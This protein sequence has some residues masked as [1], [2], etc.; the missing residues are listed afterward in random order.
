[1]TFPVLVSAAGTVK[2]SEI[3]WMGT[4]NSAN[5]E[6]LELKNETSS[7]VSLDGWTLKAEDGQPLITLSG[8]LAGNGYFLLERT[9]DDVV[10][11]VAAD[12]I[13]SGA[14]SNTGEVL[15]LRDASGIEQDRMNASAGWPAGDNTTKDTMQLVD[16][17]WLTGTPTPKQQN[18]GQPPATTNDSTPIAT[19]T[20][21]TSS[22]ATMPYIAPEYKPKF[23]VV[24]QG[25]KKVSTY[26]RSTF[27]ASAVGHNGEPLVG[28]YV[29]YAWNFGDG[30]S[31]D[32]MKVEKAFNYPGAYIIRLTVIS[33]D[34]QMS[35]EHQVR[36]SEHAVA[37]SEALPGAKGWIELVNDAS[38][39]AELSG[40]I[41]TE[42]SS[43]FVFPDGSI[44]GAQSG[45]VLD[46]NVTGIVLPSE[47]LDVTLHDGNGHMIDE[48]KAD[49][50]PDGATFARVGAVLTL[51]RPTPGGENIALIPSLAKPL[52]LASKIFSAPSGIAPT[53][54][55]ITQPITPASAVGSSAPNATPAAQQASAN[56]TPT[57]PF[58]TNM[59]WL[60]GSIA[61]GLA[62]GG[63]V[64]FVMR[65]KTG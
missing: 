36:V 60:L 54:N 38:T 43:R 48:L 24:I 59:L 16:G 50:V 39:P 61:G 13:Y 4:A 49:R 10:P 32:G 44:I 3:A 31:K 23:G 47:A 8:T 6:W 9:D 17:V 37:L 51:A 19:S 55:T 64:R 58:T 53:T 1:M 40:W 28:P 5:D 15:V 21:Q 12:L 22:G 11:G 41:L 29:R 56:N 7:P 33:G 25:P 30:T 2:I 14:L 52:T 35:T 65:R 18:A 46:A 20:P 42:G 27:I 57:P 45:I 62:I 26:A 63:I 34:E